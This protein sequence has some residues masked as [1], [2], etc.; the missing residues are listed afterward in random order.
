[1]AVEWSD[2]FRLQAKTSLVS[3]VPVVHD[4]PM[5]SLRANNNRRNNRPERAGG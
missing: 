1:M 4:R 5:T 3:G 2:R